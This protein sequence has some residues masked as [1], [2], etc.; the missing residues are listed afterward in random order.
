MIGA[1]PA[2]KPEPV[3]IIGAD[4]AAKPESKMTRA[5]RKAAAKAAKEEQKRIAA[6]EYREAKA[7]K[8][9]EDDLRKR[10]MAAEAEEAKKAEELQKTEELKKTEEPKKAEEVKKTEDP[11]TTKADK[12][13]VKIPEPTYTKLALSK[14]DGDVK[15][16]Q[17]LFTLESKIFDNMK[18][19]FNQRLK[20]QEAKCHAQEEVIRQLNIAKS[21]LAD[22]DKW[23]VGV[24]ESNRKL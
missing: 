18:E 5:E 17:S 15:L 22:I 1:D 16:A 9:E 7:K 6:N 2:A 20:A 14:I 4:L 13:A 24:I 11:K 12:P 8:K 10:K 23:K 19:S 3:R 21:V